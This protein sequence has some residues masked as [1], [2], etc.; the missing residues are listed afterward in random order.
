MNYRTSIVLMLIAIL[1]AVM[2]GSVGAADTLAKGETTQVNTKVLLTNDAVKFTDLK[3]SASVEVSVDIARSK[4]SIEPI[5]EDPAVTF[6][7]EYKNDILKETIVLKEDRYLTFPV[8]ISDGYHMIRTDDNLWRIIADNQDNTMDGITALKPWGIDAKGK[9]IE[10]DY[11]WDGTSLSLEYDHRDIEYPLT[12][13]PTWVS[14]LSHW[15]TT[16]GSYTVEM[17]NQSGTATW[18][19]PSIVTNLTYLLVGG[20]GNGGSGPGGGGAAGGYK[21][22]TFVSI[23]TSLS[24]KVGSAGTNSTLSNTTGIFYKDIGGGGVGAAAFTGTAAAGGNGVSGGGGVGYGGDNTNGAGGSSSTGGNVGG[25]GYGQACG[26]AALWQGAGGGGAGGVGSS[27]SSAVSCPSPAAGGNGG[28]GTSN[29]ITGES[30]CYAGGG[31]AAGNGGAAGTATCGGG[32]ASGAAGTNGL[33]GGGASSSGA[34]GAGTVI[35][36]YLTPLPPVASF[37]QNVTTGYIPTAVSFTDTTNQTPYAWKWGAM[38]VTPGNNTW[39]QFSTSQNPTYSFGGGNWSL[40][41]TATN[42]AGSNISIQTAWLNVSFAP[43][44]C[45]FTTTTPVVTSGTSMSFTISSNAVAGSK[46]NMSWGDGTWT[47]QTVSTAMSKSY[48]TTNIYSPT[49]YVTSNGITNSTTNSEYVGINSMK[50]YPTTDGYVSRTTTAAWATIRAGSGTAVDS[51]ATTA[52][53]RQTATSSASTYNAFNRRIEIYNPAANPPPVSTT[54]TNASL[55]SYGNAHSST[56]AT[57][58]DYVVTNIT[59]LASLDSI[60]SSDFNKFGNTALSS[61][62]ITYA[63]YND[64]GYNRMYLNAE[65]IL[66]IV[67]TGAKTPFMLRTSWD[68]DNAP[69]TWSASKTAYFLPFTSEQAGTTQDPFLLVNFTASPVYFTVNTTVGL[70]GYNGF[71]FNDISPSDGGTYNWSFGDGTY[72]AVRNATKTYSTQ[73]LFTVIFTSPIGG[74]TLTQA[75]LINI[76]APSFYCDEPLTG[77]L[78]LTVTCHDTSSILTGDTHWIWNDGTSTDDGTDVSHTYTVA[79]SYDVQ[80]QTPSAAGDTTTITNYVNAGVYPPVTEFTSNVTEV[81]S[82]GYVAFTD[83]STNTP[84]SWKWDFAGGTASDSVV[85]NPDRQFNTVGNFSVNLTATNDAGPDS[86][87]KSNYIR[88]YP[89]GWFPGITPIT[90]VDFTVAPHQYVNDGGSL[91]FAGTVTGGTATSY[92]WDFVGGTGSNATTV[93][94][95]YAF[96]PSGNRT[97]NFTAY[98]AISSASVRKVDY[99]QVIGIGVPYANYYAQPTTGTPGALVSFI[100]ESLKGTSTGLVYNWSFGDSL[101]GQPFSTIQ[102][103]VQHVYA[104]AGVYDTNLSITNA[105]GTSYMFKQQYI[106]ISTSQANTWYT[107]HQVTLKIVDSNGK[108]LKNVAVNATVY[109]SSLP[110]GITGAVNSLISNYGISQSAAEEMVDTAIHLSGTTGEDGRI[111]FTMMGSLKYNIVI[112]DSGGVGYARSL[113][114][115]DTYYTIYTTGYS[116]LAPNNAVNNYN[117]IA[118]ATLTFTEPNTSF[119]TMGVDYRD[120]S[121]NTDYLMLTVK[122]VVNGTIIYSYNT[123]VTGTQQIVVNKTVLNVRGEQYRWWYDAHRTV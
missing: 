52:Y 100:D 18:T 6:T 85:Q 68:A 95:T 50:Y 42:D 70:I 38:N 116:I 37:T 17:W 83:L 35:I 31:A 66:K 65:G 114:P 63:N 40:N 59:A 45:D 7:Y 53:A 122:N 84:T 113:Y 81:A 88:V 57:N 47:N 109:E 58:P 117:A 91:T 10:M 104:Y 24:I 101:S 36:R 16:D 55:N 33:G 29:S 72:S 80:L 87:V 48:S 60:T 41:L 71:Q 26:G 86:E 99:I 21:T 25:T 14:Y 110:G 69:P 54:I 39:L 4:E 61:S 102:G 51:S 43:P 108:S 115:L 96:T 97:V 93:N 78:P 75:N 49:L 107:P 11:L 23:S 64:A 118:N 111:V 119:M 28:A 12:I 77:A 105:N 15:K 98:N 20:G 76:S 92:K 5:K 67:R 103:N 9:Y 19:K 30:V 62:N 34:G 2:V 79:G 13:D 32:I 82:G 90:S 106:T 121:G 89:A 46:Y 44:T 3:T 22:E 94:P 120:M 8:K 123:T 74:S 56:F 1:L 73:G 112:T 27:I